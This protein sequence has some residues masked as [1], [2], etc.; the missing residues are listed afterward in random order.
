MG[1]HSRYAS[2]SFVHPSPFHDRGGFVDSVMRQ[3]PKGSVLLAFSDST[4]LPLID[5]KGFPDCRCI[6]P[7]PLSRDDFE[8]AF[9]KARTLKLAEALGVDIPATHFC[10]GE[11]DLSAILPK[12]TYPA[13]VKP[14]RSLHWTGDAGIH[15]TAVFAFSADELKRECAALKARTGEFPLVQEYVRGEEVGV[16]FLCDHGRPVA[17]CAHRRIRSSPPAGGPGAV[18][19][20]IPLGYRG[21][22]DKARKL[23]AALCWHGPIMVEFKIDRASGTPRLM[24]INGRFWGSLPLAIAAGAD[25]PHLYYRLAL[26][27]RLAPAQEYREGVVSRHWQADFKSLLYVLF[28]SDRLRPYAYPGRMKAVW[29]F[30]LSSGRYH[31]DVADYADMKPALVEMLDAGVRLL[32]KTAP[33]PRLAT[34]DGQIA[35]QD[36]GLESPRE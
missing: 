6:C 30:L 15:S 24:E 17:A 13:V 5:R 31:P 25:F 8:I 11:D 34:P 20:T 32:R 16:E 33:H 21:L 36:L 12:V 29:D 7:L 2:S 3:A 28:K 4:L 23:A 14:R 1:L 19:E 10:A 27:E 35:A 9:D 18:K 22:G 26:G